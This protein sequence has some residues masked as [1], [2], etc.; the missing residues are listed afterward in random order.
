MFCLNCGAQLPSNAKFCLNCGAE[1]N[2]PDPNDSHPADKGQTEPVPDKEGTDQQHKDDSVRAAI[3]KFKEQMKPTYVPLVVCDIIVIFYALLIPDFTK[4]RFYA[5]MMMENDFLSMI[6][7]DFFSMVGIYLLGAV[8]HTICAINV[9]KRLN[10]AL[11][12][13]GIFKKWSLPP[14]AEEDL[15]HYRKIYTTVSGTPLL[16]AILIYGFRALGAM[17]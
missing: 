12:Q 15:K 9:G 11:G 16:G 14:E 1:I 4:Y 5:S 8:L 2:I 3:A 7:K 10:N 17:S 13:P 6:M